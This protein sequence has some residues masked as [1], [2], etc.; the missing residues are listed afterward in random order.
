MES[1]AETTEGKKKKATMKKPSSISNCPYKKADTE[2]DARKRS[3]EEQEQKE[4]D[5]HPS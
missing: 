3:T 4:V 2:E 5:Q 1:G